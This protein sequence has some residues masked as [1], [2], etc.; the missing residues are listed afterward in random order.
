MRNNSCTRQTS[1]KQL[2]GVCMFCQGRFKTFKPFLQHQHDV[3]ERLFDQLCLYPVTT[4]HSI[5]IHLYISIYLSAHPSIVVP[6]QSHAGMF[7][8]LSAGEDLVITHYG[9]L[10][11]C[12]KDLQSTDLQGQKQTRQNAKVFYDR[13]YS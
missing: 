6:A 3:N 7:G 8:C 9:H 11:L 10:I 12:V 13:H 5:D 4:F 2:Q 1:A